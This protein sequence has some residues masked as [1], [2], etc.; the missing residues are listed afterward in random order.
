MN[1]NEQIEEMA[2]TL[3]ECCKVMECTTCYTCNAKYLF[4]KGYRKVEWI[5]VEER[6]PSETEY[7][8]VVL[9]NEDI[10]IRFFNSK[11]DRHVT[12][13]FMLNKFLFLDNRGDWNTE[14]RVTHWMPLPELPSGA[15]MRGEDDV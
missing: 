11:N 1:E 8:L 9:D 5:S 6:L 14:D 12:F 3:K 13:Y 15:D 4:A 2:E 7:Y 10:D